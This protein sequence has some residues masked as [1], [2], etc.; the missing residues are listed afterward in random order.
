MNNPLFP[1][2]ETYCQRAVQLFDTI[3]IE[4]KEILAKIA[5]YI[6]QKK[7]AQLPIQLVYIC[8]HNSRRSHFGQV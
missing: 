6:Q 2:I 3:A 5:V 7:D 4:R 8:T 1:S